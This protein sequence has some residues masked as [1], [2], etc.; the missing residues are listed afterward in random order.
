FGGRVCTPARRGPGARRAAAISRLP[1]LPGN[2]TR[3]LAIKDVPPNVQPTAN[4][5]TAS[6]DYFSVMGISLLRGRWVEDRD[7]EGR[8]RGAVISSSMAQRYWTGRDPIGQHF[9]I[10]VPGPEYTVVGVVGDVRSASL[11]LAPQPT[12]YVPYRQDAFPSMVIVAK[13]P[14]A[15]SSMTNAIRAAFWDVDK[16]QPARAVLT[17][18]EQLSHSLQRRR[19]S[20]T[21][22][23][24]FGVVAALLAAV[25]LYG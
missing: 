4:Y 7:P 19:F 16:D 21:L 23:S 18:D 24:I 22:L 15:A 20:V 14:A 1:L 2:S 9:Q 10:D 17:M 12:L 6:P 11:E 3:G 5:R 8:P 25:R 13:T